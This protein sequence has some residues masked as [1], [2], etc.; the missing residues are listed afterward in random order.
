MASLSPIFHHPPTVENITTDH[1]LISV[2]KDLNW[3]PTLTITVSFLTKCMVNMELE[4]S[5][6][7][8]IGFDLSSKKFQISFKHNIIQDFNINNLDGVGRGGIPLIVQMTT[9][10]VPFQAIIFSVMDPETYKFLPFHV[11]PYDGDIVF[12][13]KLNMEFKIQYSESTE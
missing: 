3:G 8:G 11:E 6:E 10:P 13:E 4:P 12:H 9:R 7:F 1:A 5:L 2:I